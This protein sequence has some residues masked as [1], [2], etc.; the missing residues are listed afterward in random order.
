MNTVTSIV[1]TLIVMG[2]LVALN[3]AALFVAPLAA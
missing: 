1:V 2:C 3:N